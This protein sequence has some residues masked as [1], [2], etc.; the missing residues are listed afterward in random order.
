MKR[1]RAPLQA[2][3]AF[4]QLI[5][6][7]LA[8]CAAGGA[9]TAEVDP[10]SLTS[11]ELGRALA[12]EPFHRLIPLAFQFDPTEEALISQVV[13]DGD[14]FD[15]A[16]PSWNVAGPRPFAVDI[17]VEGPSG[18]SPWLRIG[19]W[20]LEARTGEE[21]TRFENGKVA[22]DVLQL[23]AP[24]Q[25]A[26]IALRTFDEGA[27][28]NPADVRAFITLTD[29]SQL[30]T[31]LVSATSE[32]WPAAHEID[33][34]TRS[35]REDGGEIGGRICSPTSVAMVADFH[36]ASIP[37]TEMAAT[38]LDPHH[39]IYGNWNRAVQGA[40]SHGVKGRIARFSSWS[41][42]RDVLATGRPIVASI[43]ADEG[44]I[45]GAPYTKTTGHLLVI[46]GLTATG[47]VHVNDPAAKTAA[48]VKRLYRRR[49]ME[50]VWF[51]N[52]GVAYVLGED[53]GNSK[54]ARSQAGAGHAPTDGAH[55][56]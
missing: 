19:D 56:E 46:T 33:V 12:S 22:V 13:A 20:N 26:Q 45:A 31:R 55:G 30:E 23:T 4:T 21:R 39:G 2:L 6:L 37:T 36:G 50:R 32:P 11:S 52:G 27:P 8:G 49:D 7:T 43:R 38:I 44:D 41:T 24:T 25:A 17:R 53:D 34:P 14:P 16:I 40:F 48:G 28:L 29:R 51:E 9:Q 35:Q 42:V 15:E 3:C 54:P 18:W 5:L 47:A 10:P 1:H